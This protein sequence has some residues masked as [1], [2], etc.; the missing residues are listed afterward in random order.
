MSHFNSLL[1]FPVSAV[2]A[3][4]FLLC[5]LALHC[6][7][8]ESRAVGLLS[9]PKTA[10]WLLAVG[11]LLL[12]IDGTWPI[13]I[14]RSPLFA[15][16]VLLL[17]AALAMTVL[18]GLQRRKK[19]GFILNHLGMLLIVWASLFGA[20]DVTKARVM[21]GRDAGVGMAFDAQGLA[22]PLPFCVELEDFWIDYYADGISPRQF[23]S[24]LRI[25][26]Q[27]METSVNH[28]CTYRGYTLFQD[29]YDRQAGRYS[30]LQVVRDPWL[31]VVYLGMM[32][33]AL[34]SVLLLLGKWKTW[35]VLP[36]AG[37]LTLLFTYLTIQRISF[38]TLMPALRSWWFVPHVFIYM[39][40]YALMA[41]GL[42]LF[43]WEKRAMKRCND[44]M[45]K[46]CND[47]TV[48]QCNDESSP[49]AATPLHHFTATPLHHY[50]IDALAENLVRS[51]AALLIIGMLTGSV[52]ARQAWGDYW[53]WDAKENWAAVTWFLALVHLHCRDHRS[54][55]AI[56]I[57][58]LTFLALQVTWYGVSYLPSA[59]HSLHTYTSS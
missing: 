26:G 23:T 14:H 48:K 50:T 19:P 31:P 25:D 49:S 6:F 33:L 15:V 35:Q 28:P 11:A 32:L 3:V 13:G 29:S 43:L 54:W 37:V 22:V 24:A 10:R 7:A 8:R 40:A 2:L 5:C 1:Q 52:W 51:A 46:R 21:V 17:T 39:V 34:G 9:S 47:E 18:C 4:G 42:L 30:V 12:A 59:P 57:L 38:G 36:V 20:A 27:R 44:E 16:Y 56:A 53:A 45:V 55:K 58:L 41:L